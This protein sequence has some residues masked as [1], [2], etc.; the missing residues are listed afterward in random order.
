MI[1]KLFIS[2][3]SGI[4]FT[5]IV[6]AQPHHIIVKGSNTM[7][8]MMVKLADAYMDA[9]PEELIISVTGEGSVAGIQ[10]LLEGKCNIASSS[11]AITPIEKTG[12][13]DKEVTL[14]SIIVGYDALSIVVNHNANVKQLTREQLESIYDGQITNWKEVGGNDIKIIPYSRP[15]TSGTHDF[16]QEYIMKEK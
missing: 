10:G 11:R 15:K 2:I 9:N 16:F 13:V 7:L 6:L 1:H 8:P 12:F 4:F 14:K 3:S 5:S